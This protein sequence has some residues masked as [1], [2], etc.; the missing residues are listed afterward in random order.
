MAVERACAWVVSL[1][2]ER[3]VSEVHVRAELR[4][5]GRDSAGASQGADQS[6]PA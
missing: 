4:V 5:P 3:G 6:H 2:L 1:V